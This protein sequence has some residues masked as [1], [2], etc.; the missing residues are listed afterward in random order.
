MSDARKERTDR[1]GN[2]VG[3]C[4]RIASPRSCSVHCSW[5]A[6]ILRPLAIERSNVLHEASANGNRGNEKNAVVACNGR[7]NGSLRFIR[8]GFA[9]SF[10]PTSKS[11]LIVTRPSWKLEISRILAELT[12]GRLTRSVPLLSSFRSFH[13]YRYY[14]R[15]IGSP[16]RDRSIPRLPFTDYLARL[17]R[18]FRRTEPG[19]PTLTSIGCFDCHRVT[20]RASPPLPLL[21]S[22]FLRLRD[23]KDRVD[24]YS[25]HVVTAV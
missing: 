23:L 6:I 15:D 18:M 7:S 5:T 1:D 11:R 2:R 19:Q 12:D 16:R 22:H 25:P 20:P 13:V 21:R 17:K 8:R 10:L 24:S 9:F 3:C 14:V 4:V